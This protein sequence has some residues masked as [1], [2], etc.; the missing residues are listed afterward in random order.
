VPTAIYSAI[1]DAGH[2]AEVVLA[3]GDRTMATWRQDRT[4]VMSQPDD[5]AITDVR[6]RSDPVDAARRPADGRRPGG[7]RGSTGAGVGVP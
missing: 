6:R 4:S 3:R 2:R 5:P 1:A 7:R